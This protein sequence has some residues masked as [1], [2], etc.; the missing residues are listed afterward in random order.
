[1]ALSL[2]RQCGASFA[3]AAST[4]VASLLSIEAALA[5]QG[6][7]TNAGTASSLT[8]LAMAVIVYGTSA[9]V[10]AA[11]LIGAARGRHATLPASNQKYRKQ[12][13][14]K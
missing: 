13:H 6:P 12:P 10:I 5:A 8:Q 2:M 14:A 9:L 3:L 4:I 7:G 11:G 1:M